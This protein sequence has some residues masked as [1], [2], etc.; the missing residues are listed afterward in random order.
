VAQAQV[1]TLPAGTSLQVVLETYLNTRD[2]K[3]GEPFRS[4]LVM[5]V[6]IDEQEVL[7]I[8]AVIEGTVA[9]VQGP[10]RVSGRAEMQLRPEKVTLPNGEVLP[11]SATITGGTAGENTQIDSEEGTIRASGK[12]G[13]DVR[14]T[15]GGATTGAI[16]GAVIADQVAGGGIG[17]GAA[18]GAGAVLA[19]AV[20]R[21]IF[22]R[23]NE[24]ELP[25]GSEIRLELN[26]AL[27]FNPTMQEVSPSAPRSP[28]SKSIPRQDRRPELTRPED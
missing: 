23:G 13:M 22:K 6:F 21:Q 25:A 12:E 2:T 4:R 5:P 3:A 19:V 11:L 9:R 17:T 18:I 24:A 20:L 14:G 8:G 27:S 7:P 28:D 10:G 26:R 1:V 15:M 16:M